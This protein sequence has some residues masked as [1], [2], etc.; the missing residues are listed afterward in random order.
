[1]AK[2]NPNRSGA[3]SLVYSTFLGGLSEDQGNGIAVDTGGN[4][5]VTGV[6]GSPDFPVL[7]SIQPFSNGDDVFIT[8][9][10]PSGSALVFS[11]WLGGTKDDSGN[12][13]ALDSSNNI[14]VAGDT[15]SLDFPVRN[16]SQSTFGGGDKDAFLLKIGA[17]SGS[18][19]SLVI[20]SASPLTSAPSGTVYTLT[21][22][23]SGGTPPYRW[24]LA[25]GSLPPDLSLSSTGVLSGTPATSGSY[26][27]AIAVTDSSG[28]SASKDFQ[29]TI[30]VSTSTGGAPSSTSATASTYHVFPQFADGQLSD[31][32]FYRTTLM[33][34]NPS[35]NASAN[36]TLLLRGLTVPGFGLNYALGPN[37]WTIAS[38]TGTQG[39]QTGY[40]TLQCSASVE[41][42]LLYSYYLSNGTKLSEATV[43]SSLPASN[44][45]VVAD[46]REGAQL[47]I[48]I[49]NDSDQSVTYTIGVGDAKSTL[50]LAPRSSTAKFINQLVAGI[51][52]DSLGVVQVSSSNGA[53]S[54]I[55]LRFTGRIFT[56]I[57]ES[58]SRPVLPTAS[59]YHVFPQFA[60]GKF[61]DGTYYRTTGIYMNSSAGTSADCVMQLHGVSTDGESKFAV[62]IPPGNFV[63]G[64]TNGTQDLQ[65]GYATMDCSA[66]VDAQEVY[67]YYSADGTKLA[68]ATVFSSPAARSVQILADDREGALVGLAIA[69]DSDQLN[70]Y[71]I[72]AGDTIGT[73]TL[74]P[75]KAIAKFLN[76]FLT[77]PPNYVGPVVVSSDTGTASI[78]GLRYTGTVFT[79]IPETIRF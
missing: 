46:Q 19:P 73:V 16:A 78:I 67:S 63:V 39:P 41:A 61:A 64:T 4:A 47:G 51:P 69:N 35:S 13:I 7:H 53:A 2:L 23:A 66:P 5:Y 65:A 12:A 52:A 24:T 57:P 36:C 11:T 25:S 3:A 17:A 15:G 70:K 74:A 54:V 29:I 33:I 68:E 40:A 8:E 45:S 48:A 38:T 32:T 72:V 56:T 60:D 26:S 75:R 30:T 21:F 28:S 62:S 20:T 9:L 77:L 31:G 50:T 37:G 76:Q 42:Q 44:V 22:A 55:G 34:S 71:T 10:N 58:A 43:F 14:Y 18:A 49:A 59:V 27:F 79:T 1:V 6:T